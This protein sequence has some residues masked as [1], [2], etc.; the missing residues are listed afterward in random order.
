MQK[1]LAQPGNLLKVRMGREETYGAEAWITGF[2]QEPGLDF[3]DFN[4]YLTLLGVPI[5]AI[6]LT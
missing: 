5:L 1:F 4:P 3:H 2:W 6:S